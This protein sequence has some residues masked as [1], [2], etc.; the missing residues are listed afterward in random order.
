[1]EDAYL[2]SKSTFQG[3]P[4]WS[5]EFVGTGP[6]KVREFVPGS[7][8]SMVANDDYLL[9]RPKLDEIEVRFILDLDTI[10]SNLLAGTVDL[11]VGRGFS[12]EQA[13]EIRRQWQAGEVG[14]RPRS[15]IVIYPQ[16]LNPS[17][18]VIGDVRFRRALMYATDRQQMMDTLQGGLTGVAHVFLNPSEPEYPDVQDSAVR[19]EYDQRQAAQLIEELG[20]RKGAEGPYRDAAGQPL[21]VE[22]RNYGVKIGQRATLSL[23]DE[24]TRFGIPTEPVIIPPQR[25]QDR[26]YMASF[27]GF[28]IYRQPDSAMD[29]GRLHGSQALTPEARFVGSNFA[30]YRNAELDSLIDRYLATVPRPERMEVL[31]QIVYHVSD[32]LNNMGLFYDAELTMVSNRLDHITAAEER[33]WSIH[34]WDLRPT[35]ER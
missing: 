6:F 16:F 9:G 31:R 11:T 19:Y 21:A 15:W 23:A 25:V 30:R 34:Q 28:L 2:K 13:L 24:W 22:I 26:E 4:Y 32:Q 1:L 5:Q 10:V 35:N 33:L 14:V 17:P 12:A 20:Y 8:V 29:I 3:L 18:S 7:Q 27:P